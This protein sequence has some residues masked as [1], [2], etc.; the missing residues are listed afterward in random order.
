MSTATKIFVLAAVGSAL[1]FGL[2]GPAA[3]QDAVQWNTDDPNL[4][5]KDCPETMPAGCKMVFLHGDGTQ[6]NTDI[7]LKF[8]PGAKIARPFHSSA[9]HVV[10]LGGELKGTH[11]TQAPSSLKTGSYLFR[12][13]K[14]PHAAECVSTTPCIAVVSYESAMDY[15][16]APE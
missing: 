13:A 5:W 16:A 11:G 4:A 12:P 10:M 6:P 3:A 9:E 15:V 1:A 14:V 8:P 2:S 7:L